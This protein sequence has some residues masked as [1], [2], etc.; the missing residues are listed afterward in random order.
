[1]DRTAYGFRVATGRHP[2]KTEQLAL[3]KVYDRLQARY[4]GNLE[5]ARKLIAVGDAP[6]NPRLDI[7]ELA[8]YT[9]VANV[10]LNLDEVMTRE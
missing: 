5:A 7:V 3:A 9:S 10:I 2:T 6:R 4:R 1:M 8:V